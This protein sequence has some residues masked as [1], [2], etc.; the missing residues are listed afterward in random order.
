M[1]LAGYWPWENG[2]VES[3]HGRM[4]DEC[5]NVNLFYTLDEARQILDDWRVCYNEI[6]PHRSLGGM[7]P[8]NMPGWR[9]KTEER[10]PGFPPVC[11][12]TVSGERSNGFRSNLIT[13][14]SVGAGHITS[15]NNEG[16]LVFMDN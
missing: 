3:F 13:G 6:R 7:P 12:G 4:R 2:Y 15:G 11:S 16:D 8:V 9:P 5:L 14:S 10:L 1:L